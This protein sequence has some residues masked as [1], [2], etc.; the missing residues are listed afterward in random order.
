[1]NVHAN[2]TREGSRSEQPTRSLSGRACIV[3]ARI[4]AHGSMGGA[5]GGA[6]VHYSDLALLAGLEVILRDLALGGCQVVSEQP[7][8]VA[9]NAMSA[10]PSGGAR[11]HRRG[12]LAGASQV[13]V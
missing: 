7:C 9:F 12:I 4:R 3:C 8:R 11:T 6:E 13:R 10:S 1:M 5:V 2:A